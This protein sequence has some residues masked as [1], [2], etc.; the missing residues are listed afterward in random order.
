M[1]SDFR[2]NSCTR[3]EPVDCSDTGFCTHPWKLVGRRAFWCLSQ[4]HMGCVDVSQALGAGT[5]KGESRDLPSPRLATY[6]RQFPLGLPYQPLGW[7]SSSY[8]LS[9]VKGVEGAW[10]FGWAGL[11]SSSSSVISPIRGPIVLPVA[12]CVGRTSCICTRA[13]SVVLGKLLELYLPHLP[14]L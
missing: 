9:D 3:R 8:L 13:N 11:R 6:P 7:P 12:Q 10:D 14:Y 4:A 1:D 2:C 5:T